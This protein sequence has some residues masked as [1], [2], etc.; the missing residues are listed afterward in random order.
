MGLPTGSSK[1]HGSITKRTGG[2]VDGGAW[3]D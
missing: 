3:S 2:S 1:R